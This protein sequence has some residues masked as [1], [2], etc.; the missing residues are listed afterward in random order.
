[1]ENETHKLGDDDVLQTVESEQ[2]TEK[3]AASRFRTHR[4]GCAVPHK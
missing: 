3:M 1:M 2:P 4:T